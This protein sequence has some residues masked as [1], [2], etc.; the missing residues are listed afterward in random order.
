MIKKILILLVSLMP[1]TSMAQLG[2]GSWEIYNAFSNVDDIVETKS[3]VY[4]L[5]QGCLY[6][7]DK[8]YDETIAYT[9]DN[10]LNDN[11]ISFI[12]YNRDGEYLAVVYTNANIDLIYDSGKVVNLGDIKEA[13]LNVTP[14]IN[15]IDFNNGQIIVATNFGLVLYDDNR[16][17][18]VE[19]G[20]YGR[21]INCVAMSDNYIYIYEK[22]KYTVYCVK[23]S[24]HIN[25]ISKFNSLGGLA[26]LSLNALNDDLLAISANSGEMR[27]YTVNH[28]DNTKTLIDNT[29]FNNITKVQPTADGV[30]CYN[31]SQILTIDS[32][33]NTS[34]VN[35]PSSLGSGKITYYNSPE[36]IWVG[37][38]TGIGQYDISGSTA[39]VLHDRFIPEALTTPYIGWLYACPTGGVIGWE[40]ARSRDPLSRWVEKATATTLNF[41]QYGQID[42]ITPEPF[43]NGTIKNSA[44]TGIVQSPTDPSVL[45]MTSWYNGL[46][47]V[48]DGVIEGIVNNTAPFKQTVNGIDIDGNGN[49][50]IAIYAYGSGYTD[51]YRLLMCPKEKEADILNPA[52]WVEVM[53][54]SAAGKENDGNWVLVASKHSNLLYHTAWWYQ[55]VAI[56]DTK[57]T[58]SNAD[59]ETISVKQFVD[60]DGKTTDWDGHQ[61]LVIAENNDGNLIIG[62]PIGIVMVSNTKAGIDNLKFTRLKV[63]RN[64]GT[65]YAD[66]LLEGEEITDIDFDASN[67]M[68]FATLNNGVYHVSPDGSTII[69]HFTAENSSLPTNRI[70]SVRCDKQSNAVYFGTEA[71]LA[72]YNST[73]APAADDYSEVYAYPNPV[74]PEYTGWIVIRNLMDNSLVKITD[75]SGKTFYTGRSEGG[76]VTWDGCDAS[77]NRVK[78]GVY[79]VFA[80][81]NDNGQTS[82]AVTKILVVQ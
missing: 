54:K 51:D 24:D 38:A 5:S 64:D 72:K 2:V 41:V 73:A 14:R 79:Y 52:S 26:V 53:P 55:G 40:R 50:V 35:I 32:Q 6:S 1:L 67:N 30:M 33:G 56:T 63:P 74:R 47:K 12:K 76:M 37:D 65:N 45:Y 70:Y 44:I 46:I 7:Y 23:R 15:D 81:N 59:D 36:R 8:E 3:K 66:Y 60:Q 75:A 58:L 16:Y 61:M 71:G 29:G 34:T 80:S 31:K 69:S 82:G 43:T 49:F 77:G 78:T 11:G 68:W 39:E 4:Y 20:N 57:G 19:S 9:I 25:D 27:I 22:S 62:S 13:V 28:N 17:E 10:K 18:V 21:E 42:N 48:K